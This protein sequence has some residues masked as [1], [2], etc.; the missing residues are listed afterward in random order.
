MNAWN[1]DGNQVVGTS[2][3]REMFTLRTGD[4]LLESNRKGLGW[5]MFAND[6]VF[7]V[8]HAGD[9]ISG[10]SVLILLPERKAA[11]M[12]LINSAEGESLKA[13]FSNRFIR[14]AGLSIP[15]IIPGNVIQVTRQETEPV[16]LPAGTLAAHTGDYNQGFSFVTVSA[17]GDHLVLEKNN[18]KILLKPLTENEFIPWV[19]HGEDSQVEKS[20]E[21]Y[22]FLDSCG[23]H[24][25]FH[26]SGH[27]ESRLGYR[28]N[29]FDPSLFRDWLGDYEH[30]G[31][32]LIAG[33]TK[34]K[35]AGLSLSN[36]RVLMLNLVAYDGEYAF[37]LNVISNEYA[38]TGGMGSGFGFTVRFR[39]DDLYRII[40]FGGITFRSSK[41]VPF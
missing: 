25:L 32:Q 7:A 31:Y 20:T 41:T 12:I 40:D 10:H 30:Y 18:T 2:T 17:A 24:M 21:R 37:P 34:F 29:P 1:G 33:D 39:E 11:G 27:H 35:G 3:I 26:E 5:F 4:V 16:I 13:E 15:D 8:A 9:G 28:L 38:V 19:E 23:F 36:D 14:H 22:C 6:T